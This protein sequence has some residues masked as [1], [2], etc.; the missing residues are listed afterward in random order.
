[1]SRLNPT[2]I[3]VDR[4]QR[5]WAAAR[6]ARGAGLF[7]LK[8]GVFRPATDMDKLAVSVLFADH[9]DALWVGTEDGLG[10][11]N[12]TQVQMLTT[13]NGLSANNVR[14]I[15]QDRSGDLWIGTE[16]GGL[17]RLHQGH[18]T[19][20]QQS[21]GFPSDNIS[22]LY[23]DGDDVLWVGTIGNGL[24]R[25]KDGKTTHYCTTNGLTAN[26]INYLIE[27]DDGYLW[28][29]SNLGLMRV[30]KK[31]LND[32]AAGLIPFVSCRDYD[33]RDGLPSSECASG[34]QPAVCRTPD[35]TS[36]SRRWPA[37][38]SPTR[39]KSIPTPTRRRW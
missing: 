27:D 25:F 3:L 39:P 12:G 4:S 1:M 37:S 21:N 38:F 33:Q 10:R 19:S 22:S 9:S 35:G 15:A 14:A 31:D 29:G 36:G 28:M 20:F 26:S 17:N 6:P 16:L 30:R 23:V 24:I 11:L 18:F 34:S 2:A 5:V 8:D 7:R 13:S 32:L